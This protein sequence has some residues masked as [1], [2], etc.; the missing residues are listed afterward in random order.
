MIVEQRVAGVRG[1][2][3]SCTSRPA[4]AVVG[5]SSGSGTSAGS[6]ARAEVGRPAAF[7]PLNSGTSAGSTARGQLIPL[8]RRCALVNDAMCAGRGLGGWV[9]VWLS[10]YDECGCGDG[11]KRGELS[12]SHTDM[13]CVCDPGLAL[14]ILCLSRSVSLDIPLSLSPSPWSLALLALPGDTS[15]IS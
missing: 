5:S 12:I 11:H 13:P 14:S 10:R 8:S 9:D 7:A 4:A 15:R 1:S 2:S 6:T 3:D